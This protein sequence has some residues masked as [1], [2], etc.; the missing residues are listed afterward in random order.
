MSLPPAPVRR[1]FL[2]WERALL[3]QA[4]AWL[5]G[6]WDGTRPLDLSDALVLVPT[7]QSGRRLR[8]ALAEHAAA[9]GAAVFPPRVHTPDTW[10]AQAA[11][12]PDVASRLQALLAWTQVLGAVD[13]DDVSAVLPVPPPRRDFAWAW[14]MAENLFRVQTQLM[15]GGLRFVDVVERTGADFAEAER[16]RQLAWLEEQQEHRLAALALREPHAARRDFAKAPALAVEIRR[17]VLLAAPDPLP[18]ALEALAVAGVSV[19]VDVVVFAPEA[20]GDSFDSWGRAVPRLWEQRVLGFAEFERQVHL[21][22]DPTAEAQAAARLAARYQP[23]PDGLVAIGIADPETL[24]LLEN[25]LTR[26]GVASYNPEG[27]PRRGEQLY[28]LLA[29]L[30]SLAREPTFD[31]VATLARCPDFLD[32][33][34]ARRGAGASAARFL[35]QL[36]ELRTRH[37]P[38]DLGA[39]RRSARQ[40]PEVAAGLDYV[41]ELH[42]TLT[43]GNF[44]EN[45]VAALGLIFRHRRFDVSREAD[46]RLAGAAEAWRD[47]MQ[48]CAAARR[49][50][51]EATASDWW[52]VALRLLGD[53]RRTE[54]KPAGALDLQGWLE[55]LWEDAP[56]LAVAGLND[57]LVPEAIVGDA[58]LPESLREQLGLK[59][60]AAR[61]ARDAY[62]L[63]AL[64]AARAAGGRLDLFF[65]KTSASGDPLRPSR[66]LLR[67]AEPDLPDRIAFLFR[68]AETDHPN[69]P[70]TRAWQLTPRREPPPTRVSVTA[71]RLWLA[72]PFRFYLTHV[73]RMEPVEPAKNEMDAR[74]FGTLCHAALEAL[75]LAPALRD[76]TDE[77]TLRE[78]LLAEF[79][80][81]ARATLGESH[82]LPVVV[83]LESARQRLGRAA[84]VRARDR[85]EGWVIER[86]EWK[87]ALDLGGLE[88]RG[89]IDRIDRH[90]ASGA[91]RVL[92]YKTSD[93]AV[94][95]QKA[96][97]RSFRAGDEVLPDW[98]RVELNGREYVWADLQLPLYL[99][100]LAA[101]PAV[102][103]APRCG[104][105]NLPKAVSETA[106][107]EWDELTP[108]L[109]GAADDCT[110]AVAA[111]I[112][113]GVFWPPQEV[114]AD[115][116]AFAAL[117]H[118][119]AAA[120]VRWEEALP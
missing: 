59:T 41:A 50:Y 34:A 102:R 99:R 18:L 60:N 37:L 67:C 55:L 62:I 70:W 22:A 5:A 63:R 109:I 6:D 1:H 42:E 72:C 65:A 97:L 15:E 119:G 78:F 44:P 11:A 105:F 94:T 10:L 76:C 24:P 92:D 120:S 114:A 39:A 19:P 33:L 81:A 45:A 3:P 108:D 17:I 95:P 47:I 96:H 38:A 64:G 43:R 9:R 58:F 106:I 57:G 31:A 7:R 84:A 25:E 26:V 28:A 36:D 48:Q 61:F 104:Y 90:E 4:A 85:A 52:D 27:R 86:A 14:R 93:T 87:F 117:F 101:D 32:G 98:M 89:K 75:A 49:D 30:G 112:R 21:C 51:P 46:A 56:H 80:A 113:A 74:D 79:D 111:A 12:T 116:D 115:R 29:A 83:Q 77:K 54:E 20:E 91:W 8:E 13:L 107:A 88:V 23:Q 66:L 2:S 16:W 40:R 35:Q 73:L 82:T 53:S 100:A 71:L 118:H 69:L 103:G 110:N 68:P